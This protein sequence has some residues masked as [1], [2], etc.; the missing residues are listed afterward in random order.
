MAGF[1]TNGAFYFLF[2]ILLRYKKR[3]FKQT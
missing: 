3:Y 2:K 1:N